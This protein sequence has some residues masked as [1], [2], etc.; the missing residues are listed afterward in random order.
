MRVFRI[1]VTDGS[2]D[3]TCD[4]SRDAGMENRCDFHSWPPQ[5][6]QTLKFLKPF[7]RFLGVFLI[8]H[9]FVVV[10]LRTAISGVK[11]GLT[12]EPVGEPLLERR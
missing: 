10:F 6:S 5:I 12:V 11:E 4:K 3:E 2:S 9:V 8:V 1:T 7:L